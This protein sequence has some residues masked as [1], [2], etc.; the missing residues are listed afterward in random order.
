MTAKADR[1]KRLLDDP[2]IEDAF[3]AV[4]EHY[5]D[6]IEQVP[7][8]DPELIMDIRKMLHLLTEVKQTLRKAIQDGALED[9][10]VREQQGRGFL[11]DIRKW[12]KKQGLKNR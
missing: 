11:Q 8:N 9:F 4:R 1:I 12:P 5:R 2:D 3:K 7:V 6:A 10:R